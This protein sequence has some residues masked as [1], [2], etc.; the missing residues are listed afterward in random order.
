MADR[1]IIKY[2]KGIQYQ[3]KLFYILGMREMFISFLVT[4]IGEK[5]VS[6]TI[7]VTIIQLPASNKEYLCWIGISSSWDNN[8]FPVLVI[9]LY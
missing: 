9:L 4:D 1:E 2:S 8:I 6:A 3:G 5:E 7:S